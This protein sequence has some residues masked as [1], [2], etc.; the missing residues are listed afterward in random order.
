MSNNQLT[1]S[2]EVKYVPK[3]RFT[4]FSNSWTISS[5]SKISE[6]PLYGMNSASKEFDGENKYL[7]ITDIDESTRLFDTT[8]LTSPD[9]ELNNKYLLSQD[10]LLFARTGASVGKSYLYNINDGK[11]FF[12]GFLIKFKIKEIVIPQFI[13]YQTLT[14]SY[15]TWVKK[16]SARSGQPGINAEE[17]S[18]LEILLTSKQEQQKIVD[19]LASLDELIQNE[20]SKLESYKQHR[21]GLLQQL[22]PRD[23]ESLP[24]LR[25]D[26]FNESWRKQKIGDFIEDFLDK[27]TSHDEYEVFTSSKSGLMKQTEYYEN[28]RLSTRDNSGFNI[29]PPNYITYRSRSDNR[30]FYFNENKSGVTGLISTYYPVFKIVNGDNHFFIELFSRY[31]DEIGKYSIGTSQTVLSIK[32]LKRI[33][34]PIPKALEEQQKI[35]KCLSSIDN[36][37]MHQ[38]NYI[39]QLKQ[40]K[41]GLM[42]QLFPVLEDVSA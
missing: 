14:S 20:S 28:S 31:Q 25:F 32:E 10:D 30:K 9:G 21:N 3:L 17:Y 5:L 18:G 27:S 19:C 16:T 15:S 1:K 38:T 13:F 8:K 11:V 41:K 4:E 39:E 33:S 34:L 2:D 12:A 26:E 36:L 24:S 7:R 23:G 37:V 22:F 42:Q 29:I 40:H 6:K 35:A